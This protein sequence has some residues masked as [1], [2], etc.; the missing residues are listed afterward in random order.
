MDIFVGVIVK[1]K[2]GHRKGCNFAVVKIDKNYVYICDG[3]ERKLENPKKK[4]IK[5][6]SVTAKSI[7]LFNISNK[8][9]KT[10]L[11]ELD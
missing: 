1:S 10:L 9:L 8:K 2:A 4:N 5:H 11:N 7:D 3:K 6:I